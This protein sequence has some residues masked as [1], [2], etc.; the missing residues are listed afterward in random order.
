MMSDSFKHDLK[1]VKSATLLSDLVVAPDKN[2]VLWMMKT[3]F[4]LPTDILSSSKVTVLKVKVITGKEFELNYLFGQN[5]HC[6]IDPSII[7]KAR[8]V[9]VSTRWF[10]YHTQE[11]FHVCKLWYG[12]PPKGAK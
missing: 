6:D 2:T 1:G 5:I 10:N 12:E 9:G 11:V 8:W 7:C 3:S 4:Y